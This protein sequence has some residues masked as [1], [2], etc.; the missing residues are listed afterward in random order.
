M[1][2]YTTEM[3]GSEHL[4]FREIMHWTTPTNQVLQ[5]TPSSVDHTVE[6]ELPVSWKTRLASFWQ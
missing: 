4:W 6:I 1:T 5:S 3:C 2:S